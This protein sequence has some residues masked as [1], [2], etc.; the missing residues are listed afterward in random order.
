VFGK[1]GPPPFPRDEKEARKISMDELS[2]LHSEYQRL[3]DEIMQA[4]SRNYQVLG[5]MVAGAVA[6]LA[7]ALPKGGGG[8]SPSVLLVYALT[9]PGYRMLCVNR[10]RIWRISTYMRVFLEKKLTFTQWET[11]LDAQRRHTLGATHNRLS[12]LAHTTEWLVVVVINL[13]TAVCGGWAIVDLT[14]GFRC[15]SIT[16][17]SVL[18]LANF[19]LVVW[20]GASEL[21]LRR[22]GKIE[23]SYLAAWRELEKAEQI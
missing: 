13:A 5:I 15:W 20:M 12:S 17:L 7:A 16:G 6:L 9:I 23:S 1:I 21:K 11:R 10:R 2:Q 19:G 8:P 18:I 14:R 4:D 3:R 22:L